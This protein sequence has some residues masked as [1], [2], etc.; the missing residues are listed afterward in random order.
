MNAPPAG[1]PLA[2]APERCG[3]TGLTEPEC[4]CRVCLAALIARHRPATA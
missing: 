3:T 1:G 2:V 4:H